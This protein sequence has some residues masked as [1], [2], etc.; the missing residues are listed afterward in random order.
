MIRFIAWRL[1]QFPLIL[2]VIYTVT[3]LLAWVAPGSPFD[4]AERKTSPIVLNYLETQFHARHW[5]EFL[6]YYPARVIFDGDF[7]PSMAYQGWSVN[8]ILKSALPVSLTLGLIAM[9]I[10]TVGGSILGV[11]AAVRRDGVFD[12]ASLFV[13]LMGISLPSFVAASL[14]L[15]IFSDQL[16]WFPSGGWGEWRQLVLPAIALSL[17]PLS[18]VA[19]LSRAAMLDVLESDFVRTARAKGLSPS[20]VIWKHCFRLAFLPV[21]SYLGPAAAATLTGSFV[22]EQVF[23]LPGLGRHF[24]NAVNNR[25]QTLILGTVMVYSAFLLTLNLLVD[26]G[27]AVIDPRIDV[28]SKG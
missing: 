22:V 25:D 16:H 18:F 2:A 21:F 4:R 8:D 6:A 3:F 17:M 26:I 12:Y 28:T 14:L 23:N 27:Y 7:G 19:R 9:G 15:T 10:A 11:F 24:V 1:A 13:A 20:T 5:Y